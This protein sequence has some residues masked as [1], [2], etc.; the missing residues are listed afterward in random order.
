MSPQP[1]QISRKEFSS[2]D[3][4]EYLDDGRRVLVTVGVLGVETDVTLRKTDEEYVCDTGLKLLTYEK[5]EE[6]KQCIER[7]RLTTAE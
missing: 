6:M 5:R 1:V 3:V 7:L 4:L 2:D